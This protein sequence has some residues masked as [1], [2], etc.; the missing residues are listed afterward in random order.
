MM[1]ITESFQVVPR[2]FLALVIIALAGPGIGK[3]VFVI[4]ILSWPAIARL[5]RA[6]FLSLRERE[7]VEAAWS[8]GASSGAI[9]AK[10]ILPNVL[11]LALAVGSLEVA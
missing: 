6:E 10:H 11:S 7:F 3:V 5:V 2:F 1:R 4:A 9:I 8:L